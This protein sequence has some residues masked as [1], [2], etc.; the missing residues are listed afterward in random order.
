MPSDP[1]LNPPAFS[2][3]VHAAIFRHPMWALT[4]QRGEN[5]NP[6]R[7]S[8]RAKCVPARTAAEFH[9]A[10]NRG[11]AVELTREPGERTGVMV[12]DGGTARVIPAVRSEGYELEWRRAM[13][14]KFFSQGVDDLQKNGPS[15]A[16]ATNGASRYRCASSAPQAACWLR[17]SSFRRAARISSDAGAG[18]NWPT[19]GRGPRP[20]APKDSDSGVELS[21]RGHEPARVG[22]LPRLDR[23]MRLDDD[24]GRF[25]VRWGDRPWGQLTL[26]LFLP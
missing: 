20:T 8:E 14:K 7:G 26:A 16:L 6:E 10:L 18:T 1:N 11:F 21:L 12:E 15:G 9:G 4:S 3:A 5:L 2:V 23:V 19:T 25:L 22:N 17:A 24:D 13:A